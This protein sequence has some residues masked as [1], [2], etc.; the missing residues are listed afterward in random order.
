MGEIIDKT[1]LNVINVRWIT[2]P[3]ANA[4]VILGRLD[5]W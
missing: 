5:A 4:N 2:I 3:T 1:I